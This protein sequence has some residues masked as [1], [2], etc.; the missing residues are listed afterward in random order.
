MST[1][2]RSQN[3]DL[4]LCIILFLNVNSLQLYCAHVRSQDSHKFAKSH[5]SKYC[6]KGMGHAIIFLFLWLSDK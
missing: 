6:F 4:V 2:C 5:K 3:Y 1:L